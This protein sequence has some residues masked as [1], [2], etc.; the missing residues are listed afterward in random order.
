V[1]STPASSLTNSFPL[2][3]TIGI[4]LEAARSSS[5][6][7]SPLAYVTYVGNEGRRRTIRRRPPPSCR[8]RC[9]WIDRSRNMRVRAVAGE[10]S[11]T[12]RD[13]HAHPRPLAHFSTPKP[14]RLPT[15][16]PPPPPTP[17]HKLPQPDQAMHHIPPQPKV[18]SPH[19]T[20]QPLPP[21]RR[22]L[23]WSY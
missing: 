22:R 8:N 11:P 6:C 2:G 21:T 20:L 14:N 13:D 1:D 9:C 5:G 7:S 10:V 12:T 19:P 17:M 23:P 4:A 15:T 18:F 16:P 3:T